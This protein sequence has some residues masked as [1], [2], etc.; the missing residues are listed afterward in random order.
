[1]FCVD[2]TVAGLSVCGGVSFLFTRR[3]DWFI[4]APTGTDDS[5][6]LKLFIVAKAFWPV[7]EIQTW[8]SHLL[9][10]MMETFATL[11]ML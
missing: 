8:L 4:L 7:V 10:L 6:K 1:M 3:S 11:R 2:A 5:T 9:V